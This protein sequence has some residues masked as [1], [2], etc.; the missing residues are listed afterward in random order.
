MRP[1]RCETSN[2]LHDG[3]IRFFLLSFFDLCSIHRL[4]IQYFHQLQRRGNLSSSRGNFSC[5]TR[6]L[7]RTID[8]DCMHAAVFYS[9]PS[10]LIVVSGGDN[11]G[12]RTESQISHPRLRMFHT[13]ETLRIRLTCRRV[14]IAM[15]H[16]RFAR[17]ADL[18]VHLL[19]AQKAA[20]AAAR[21]KRSPPPTDRVT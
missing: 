21:R 2:D 19:F 5:T 18:S 13:S 6:T 8:H 20:A 7:L 4:C 17:P 10:F 14:F 3:K 12:L 16:T 1:I 15:N 11:C 9:F